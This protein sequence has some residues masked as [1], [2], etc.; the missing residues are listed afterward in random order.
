MKDRPKA[1]PRSKMSKLDLFLDAVILIGVFGMAYAFFVTSDHALLVPFLTVTIVGLIVSCTI[2]VQQSS[3]MARLYYI[4]EAMSLTAVLII[5]MAQVSSM[6]SDL[7]TTIT[8]V[9]AVVSIV[10]VLLAFVPYVSMRQSSKPSTNQEQL[11]TTKA[12][13]FYAEQLKSDNVKEQR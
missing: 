9:G 1:T 13:Q 2:K 3:R 12:D 11:G 8:M 6:S 10:S 4:F 7:K 5:I